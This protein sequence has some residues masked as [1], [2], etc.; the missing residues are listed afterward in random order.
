MRILITNDDGPSRGILALVKEGIRRG[1]DIVVVTTEEQRSAS[2][3]SVTFRLRY[4]ES[5]LLG[6]PAYFV[7]STPASAVAFALQNI[8]KN[9]D[10]VLSGVNEGANLGVWDILSSGTVGAVLEA[11]LHGLRGIAVSLAARSKSEYRTFTEEH[12]LAAAEIAYS[13]IEQLP[14][15]WPSPVLNL[16]VPSFGN[17]GI[18]VTFPETKSSP[19]RMYR[20]RSGICEAEEWDLFTTYTCSTPGS[21]VCAIQ[22]GFTSLTPLDLLRVG[23]LEWFARWLAC[24]KR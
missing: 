1:Y 23:D 17:R 2:S 3:K 4:R 7:D 6:C 10:L 11:A 14:A 12:F 21:D 19:G 16:N 22:Q 13:I 9:F 20:C 5:E 18:K 8:S 15:S 24:E